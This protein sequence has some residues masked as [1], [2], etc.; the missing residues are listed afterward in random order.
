[1]VSRLTRRTGPW[2]LLVVAAAVPQLIRSATYLQDLLIIFL[3]NSYLALSWNILSGYAGQFSFGHATFFG[4]GA[5]TST[6]LFIRLGLSPWLGLLAGAVVAGLVGGVAGWASFKYGL[7]GAFFALVTFALSGM[8]QVIAT[9]WK[10]AGGAVGLL[11]PL[12][13][14]APL[15]FQFKDK[16]AYY[17][18]VL[19]MVAGAVWVTHRIGRSKIGFYLQAIREEE[20]GAAVLGIDTLRYKTLAMV[21][22]SAMTALGGTFYA[23]WQFY[24]DPH[25]GFGAATS[26]QTLLGAVVGGVGTI[27][28]PVL[29]SG[30]LTALSELTKELFRQHPGIDVMLYGLVLM[31]I[32]VFLP[33]GL[34]GLGQKFR[35]RPD[36]TATDPD[37]SPAVARRVG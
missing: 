6:L 3:L 10:W 11:I 22:S 8:F 29:G 17:Y 15:L 1:M 9:N 36:T 26:I 32:V 2:V 24:L 21:I 30:V 18:V 14:H 20:T 35:R 33:Q 5:Y 13:G 16:L 34:L 31:G 37:G 4:I 7:R 25:I 19:G 23:Q 12:K 28:G 27:W